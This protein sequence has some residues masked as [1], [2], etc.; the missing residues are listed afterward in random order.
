MRTAILRVPSWSAGGRSP[1]LGLPV[2]LDPTLGRNRPSRPHPGGQG[3]FGWDGP[4]A[5]GAGPT[6]VNLYSVADGTVRTVPRV[7]RT[8][9]EW[10]EQLTPQQF[11]VTRKQGTERAFTGDEV[12]IEIDLHDGRADDEF[13]TCDLTEEYVR[14][15]AEY[16]T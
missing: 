12:V 9:Q 4:P 13:I 7:V 6:E 1:T 8:E 11:H 14:I 15:N 3:G 16:S 10:R 2:P 5:D